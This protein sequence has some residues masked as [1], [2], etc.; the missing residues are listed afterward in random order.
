MWDDDDFDDLA[1]VL[2]E[3]VEAVLSKTQL[4]L[5]MIS[6]WERFIHKT[7]LTMSNGLGV[8]HVCDSFAK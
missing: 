8:T 1:N 6:C 3:S 5:I 7:S 2:I 4:V